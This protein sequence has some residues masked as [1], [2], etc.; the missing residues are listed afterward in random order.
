[1]GQNR[2][3][4]EME[5]VGQVTTQPWAPAQPGLTD[6]IGGVSDLFNSGVLSNYPDFNTVAGMGQGT[7]DAIAGIRNTAANPSALGAGASNTIQGILGGGNYSNLEAMY[8]D[9]MRSSNVGAAQNAVGGILGNNLSQSGASTDAERMIRQLIGQ[10]SPGL[11][12]ASAAA[13]GIAQGNGLGDN[14]WYDQIFGRA[15]GPTAADTYL[16][17]VAAGPSQNPFLQGILDSNAERIANQ[18]KASYAQKGRY[19]SQDFTDA[20]VRG[21]AEY[22]NPIMAAAYDSDRNRQLQAVGMLDD[23]RLANLGLGLNTAS[24]RTSADLG[25]ANTRL[26]AA[27]LAPAL[28]N[29]R[30]MGADRLAA[31]GAATDAFNLNNR[32]QQLQAAQTAGALDAQRYAGADRLAALR[33]NEISAQLAAAQQAGIL[34]QNRYADMDRLLSVG[35]LEDKAAQDQINADIQKWFFEN[36][37]GDLAALQGLAGVLGP[38]AGLGGTQQQQ[39]PWTP[40]R[41]LIS[42]LIAGVGALGG[43]VEPIPLGR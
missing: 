18:V 14:A 4:G 6:L 31:S 9:L 3:K 24:A 30:Y 7:L 38:I 39:E 36:G 33:Q 42:G 20:M 41:N 5:T 32:A 29:A 40:W 23:A 10:G 15:M 16:T 27:G 26:S 43:V 2:R 35:M 22:Q 13:T 19:G 28:E 34:D 1:M 8:G 12:A 21:I 25:R 37:G 11:D 17:D